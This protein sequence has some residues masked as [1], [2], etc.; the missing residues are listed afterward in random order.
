MKFDVLIVGAGHG[1]AQ[2]AVVLRAQKFEGSIA[3][4]GE[5]PELPYERPPLSK[6]YFAGDKPFERILLRP[7]KFWDERAVTMRLGKRV[8]SL[9]P[10]AH[11]VTTDS[12]ETIGYGKLVWSTGGHRHAH[13]ELQVVRH[14]PAHLA[15][16]HAHP[17]RQRSPGQRRRPAHALDRRGLKTP[18]TYLISICGLIGRESI[19][20]PRMS[21]ASRD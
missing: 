5:E 9:D 16:R 13:R 12:G 6:E 8:V 11:T 10:A 15:D 4:I 17:A 18:V 1:G 14:K 19:A 3:I 21:R 7:A 2:V 20:S